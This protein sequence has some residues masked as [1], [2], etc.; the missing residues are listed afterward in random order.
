MNIGDRARDM[1][2]EFRQAATNPHPQTALYVG[3]ALILLGGYFLLRAFNIPWLD[4]INQST[5]LAFLMIAAGIVL[6]FRFKK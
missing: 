4:W 6:L 5:L 1:G 3:G 2:D